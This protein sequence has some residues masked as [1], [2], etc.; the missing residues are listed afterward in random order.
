M[1]LILRFLPSKNCEFNVQDLSQYS[2][3]PS[4]EDLGF[5]DTV[6]VNILYYNRFN[7]DS[8]ISDPT[9]YTHNEKRQNCIYRSQIEEDGWITF[10]HLCLP[11]LS[12]VKE[13]YNECDKSIVCVE[14]CNFYIFESGKQERISKEEV[15][16]YVFAPKDNVIL[17]CATRELV[18]V[19][20][21]EEC[22]IN[23]CKQLLDCTKCTQDEEIVYRKDLLKILLDCVRYL[24][25]LNKFKEA[26][27]LIEE[28]QSCKGLCGFLSY[29]PKSC[30][31]CCS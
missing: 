16:E 30:G 4:I 17:N 19:C 26:E 10:V 8:I 2:K 28:L 1:N 23:Y 20:N 31:C 6:S 27:L 14:N 24:S 9:F 29:S 7:R 12:Y 25:E 22:Y 18:S 3:E 11:K 21:L 5:N 15:L 13:N